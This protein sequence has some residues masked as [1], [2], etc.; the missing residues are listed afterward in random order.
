MPPSTVNQI[1]GTCEA[2]T[3]VRQFHRV[4]KAVS[5]PR[6][7]WRAEGNGSDVGERGCAGSARWPELDVLSQWEAVYVRP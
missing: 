4:A 3:L 6:P 1:N 2:M 5:S 7:H